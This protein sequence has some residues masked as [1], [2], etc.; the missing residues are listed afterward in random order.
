MSAYGMRPEPNLKRFSPEERRELGLRCYELSASGRKEE[1]A[2]LKL[3]YPLTPDLAN[4]LKKQNGIDN[5]IASGI[6]L[7]R[8]VEAFGYDWLEK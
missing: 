4:V 8:A 2:R 1:A 6:N 3:E 5:L 7:S